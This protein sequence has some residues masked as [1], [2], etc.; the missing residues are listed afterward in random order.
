MLSLT[1]KS[2][3]YGA[4]PIVAYEAKNESGKTP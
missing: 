1:T 4:I 2:A 3:P